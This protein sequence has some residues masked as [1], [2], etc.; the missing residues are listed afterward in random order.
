M[1]DRTL[2]VNG[3]PFTFNRDRFAGVRTMTVTAGTVPLTDD[4]T[5]I[6]VT[7]A[8]HADISGIYTP[9]PTISQSWQQQG[10]N[11]TITASSFNETDGYEYLF[12]DADT[13][14]LIN[15]GGFVG[16]FTDRPWKVV[17]AYGITITGLPLTETVTV[18][19]TASV[20]DSDR[21]GESRP[22]LSKVVGGAA[23]AYS[24]RDLNDKQGNNKVVEVRR[25]SGGSRKFLAKEVSNGT[26]EEWVNEDVTIYQSDF[27][28]GID[29]F[30]STS[31]TTATGNQDGVSDSVGTTK[32]NVLKVVKAADSQG[33][34]QRDNGVIAGLTYTV[35]GSFFVDSAVNTA[36]DGIMIKDGLAGSSLSDY[37][38]GY[39]TSDGT[40]TDFSF[41]YTATTSGNQRVQLGISSL[42][43]N[44][45]GSSTGS[46][47]DI[48]YIADLKFVE[49]TSNGFVETWYDQ[50][51][52]GKDA[53]QAS[54]S[55]QPKIVNNGSLVTGGLL[56]SDNQHID[57]TD[58][59]SFASGSSVSLFT[60]NKATGS[61]N[62]YLVRLSAY[63][64]WRLG[65]GTRRMQV[66]TFA[67]S[68]SISGNEELWT[69]IINV[70]SSGGTGNF[71][72]DGTLA[73]SADANIGT[74]TVTNSVLNIGGTGVSNH[75]NGTIN[76]IIL[77][78]SDQTSNRP[79]I[80]ANINNQY[81]IY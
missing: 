56:F 53:V 2:F 79:A 66:G 44:P 74:S 34:M 58:T 80:E 32:D 23:A 24:L 14:P 1:A 65:G 77:Y 10:G 22:L 42:G 19:R 70:N 51:G 48:V 61:E 64:I 20:I 52:N 39:L 67:N 62:S 78:T 35:S 49:T 71:F 72:V 31:T 45:N 57:T 37:P 11:G 18:D 21:K 46:T 59:F 29:G 13:E 69:P 60:V 4:T 50:S 6:Q 76:E 47:G 15:L 8:G 30:N 73:S 68:G 33:Y 27:S 17:F 16:T 43:S 41:S 75:W 25:S 38:S 3:Q 7:V 54:S 26:L 28:A 55:Q 63:I 81:N 9:H 40:W 5:S 36:V 12:A